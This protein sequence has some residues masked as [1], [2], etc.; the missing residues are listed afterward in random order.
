MVYRLVRGEDVVMGQYW[1]ACNGG[2]AHGA[3]CGE[4]DWDDCEGR[5]HCANAQE[6]L[7]AI[8]PALEADRELAGAAQDLGAQEVSGDPGAFGAA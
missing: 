7:Q 1:G 3:R 2:P 6:E 4:A 5:K 8:C